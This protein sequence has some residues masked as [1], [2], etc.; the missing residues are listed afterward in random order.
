MRRFHEL[1]GLDAAAGADDDAE[2]EAARRCGIFGDA[3]LDLR[4]MRLHLS[5]HHRGCQR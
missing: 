1:R 4:A 3:R 2:H 5:L